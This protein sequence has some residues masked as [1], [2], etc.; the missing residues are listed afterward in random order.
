MNFDDKNMA[1]SYYEK[2]REREILTNLDVNYNENFTN[3][4]SILKW[5]P[6]K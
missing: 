3:K 4:N 2:E 6:Q 1:M 5:T